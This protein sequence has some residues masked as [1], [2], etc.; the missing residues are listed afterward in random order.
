MAR[1]LVDVDVDRHHELER[2]ESGV[3]APAVGRRQ[4]GVAGDRDQRADLALPRRVDLLREGDDG[5]LAHGLGQPA[6][7]RRVAVQAG[8]P[9]EARLAPG[10]GGAGRGAREHGAAGSVEVAREHVEDVDQPGGEGA[11]LGGRGADAPV[12]AGSRG[13]GEVAS[14]PP[15][16]VSIDAHGR[17]DDL[18][19]EV[20]A[21]RH[22]LVEARD[23]L[24]QR[25]QGHEVLRH[26]H[27]HHGHQEVGVAPR[28]HGHPLRGHLG[29]PRP[30]RVDHHE[31]PAPLDQALEPAGPVGR[32]RE[33]PVRRERV[34]T[35][36]QQ[37]VG[38]VHVG[39]GD[40]EPAAEH[41]RRA[42]LLR[43]LVH[44]RRRV[45]VGR[46]E[47]PQHGPAVEHPGQAVGG[48]VAQVGGA[49][50][51]AVLLEEGQ[52]PALDLLEGLRPGDLDVHAV[53]LDERA[54]DPVGVLVQ[55]L[56]G[57]A[58][59]ADVALAE[60]VVLVAPDAG[61][62][63]ARGRVAQ[64]DL[65]PAA[66]LAQR[67]R[68]ERGA[69]HVAPPSVDPP[70]DA[71]ASCRPGGPTRY[72]E[73]FLR[74]RV[75]SHV[76]RRLWPDPIEVD[77]VDALVAAEPR[78]TPVG[79]PWLLVNM[80][81]SLDGAI[82]VEGRSGQL[83]RPADRQVFSALRAIGDVVLAGAGTVRAEG[84]G[85]ARPSEAQRAARRARGQAEVPTIAVVTRS[86]D[87]DLD[88]ALFTTDGPRPIVITCRAAPPDRR[89][90]V[91]ERADLLVVGEDDVDL[92]AAVA[93]LA[94]RG[95]DV[96]TCEGG[97]RLNGDLLAA[98]LVDEWNLSVSPL[99]V[100]DSS[101][102]SAAGP[103]PTA[104]RPLVLARLLEGDGLVLGR[105][106]RGDVTALR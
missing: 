18:R 34:G 105:W 73:C 59:R 1:R 48:G 88:T 23:Q 14:Q 11:E 46:T 62:L 83:G 81:A 28:A 104:P 78:P 31:R 4:D 67:A 69:R 2:F 22:D 38:A 68:A 8:L 80:I 20:G 72:S 33:A 37:V 3:E 86:L 74:R 102:R 101:G 26:Q 79:R 43:A 99:L 53:S 57:R 49:R 61:D 91:G 75:A 39:H 45:D 103:R 64:G 90:R 30:A 76:V 94:A 24:A 12:H 40:V 58:L 84:Y 63:L 55:L 51:A 17:S 9:P 95:V 66:G 5:Q 44:G 77:D 106:V 82:T 27:L 35:Q 42:D 65:Q 56:Q 100:G 10:V 89:R 41:E 25:A 87:L 15:D 16:D 19:G 32:G 47:G 70:V 7:A 13:S 52:E 60:H 54:T 85:P 21:Q 29:G 98:D 97:P 36:H 71:P 92:T 6:H 50:A 93:E 96:V